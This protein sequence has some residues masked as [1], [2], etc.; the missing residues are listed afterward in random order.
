MKNEKLSLIDLIKIL[1]TI[2]DRKEM[3]PIKHDRWAVILSHLRSKQ[4]VVDPEYDFLCLQKLKFHGSDY[5]PEEL[6]DAF[7][8]LRASWQVES[9]L[10]SNRDFVDK[11]VINM[12]R[13]E[14]SKCFN[15][16]DMYAFVKYAEEL[17]EALVKKYK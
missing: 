12:W 6:Q 1:F 5:E 17:F 3:L 13:E 9:V 4:F 11:S 16:D 15:H 2:A 10:P 8:T 14:Y 7:C